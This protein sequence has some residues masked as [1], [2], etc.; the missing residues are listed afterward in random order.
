MSVSGVR[1]VLLGC[2]AACAVGGSALAVWLIVPGKPSA[3][4]SVHFEGYVL[5]PRHSMLTFLDYMTVSG[6]SLFVTNAS[7][8]AVYKVAL[9]DRAVPTAG[10]VSE[11]SSEGGGAAHGVVID[12]TSHMAYVTRSAVDAV[13]VFDP[14]TMGFSRRIPVAPDPDALAYDS[15]NK[16]F[17]VAGADS[18]VATLIDPETRSSVARIPLGG[19]PEFMVF[20]P[21]SG[22]VYQ[23]LEDRDSV[24]AVDLSKRAVVGRWSTAPCR[25]PTA[26]AIDEQARRL[27]IGCREPSLLAVVD[28]GSHRV[29]TTI[30]IG[31]GVDSVAFDPQLQRIYT[32]GLS[33]VL[34][35]IQQDSAKVYRVL[36][37]L[38]TH[39]LAHTVAVDPTTHSVYV[40]YASLLVQ[41]RVAI[42]SP[43]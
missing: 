18:N 10:D 13:D 17:Y 30:P 19:K 25:K 32:T 42:F 8:G 2:L 20:D 12:P 29:L 14:G 6:R 22:L 11:L 4:R 23:S 38:S 15:R 3:G 9:N 35:V 16:L 21:G 37:R 31:K 26:M 1:T 39:F 28:I 41:P 33:G 5:L 36:D 24:V 7:T 34:V 27:F 40:A 43:R